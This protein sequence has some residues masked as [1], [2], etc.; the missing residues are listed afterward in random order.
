MSRI[1]GLIAELCPDGVEFKRLGNIARIKNGKDHKPLDD[2]DIPVYGSGG[3]MRYP[4][5]HPPPTATPSS[6]ASL[7][8]CN[9]AANMPAPIWSNCSV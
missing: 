9:P 4:R 7:P 5:R 3:I 1:E 6:P 8:P 2:G